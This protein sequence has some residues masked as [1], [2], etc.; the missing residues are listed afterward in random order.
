MTTS[1]TIFPAISF[2]IVLVSLLFV[3]ANP[4]V[5]NIAP[6]FLIPDIPTCDLHLSLRCKLQER[7]FVT[8]LYLDLVIIVSVKSG[9]SFIQKS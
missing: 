9:A 1:K 3:L 5:G 4:L 2:G 6:R 8:I 7:V